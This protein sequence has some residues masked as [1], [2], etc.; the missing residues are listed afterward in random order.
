MARNYKAGILIT[1]DSKGA[2]KAIN[3]TAKEVEDL[4]KTT[5]KSQKHHKAYSKSIVGGFSDMAAKAA[6]WGAAAV[7][8]GAVA[9]AA[10]VKSGL[11][12]ADALAK[13]SDKLGVTTEALA[14]LRFAAEQTG[15]ETKT[16]DIALQRFT[17]RLADAAA[18][19]GPAVKA[20]DALGLSAKDLVELS[21]DKAFARVAEQMGNVDN[22]TSKVALAFKLFDSEGVALVNTLALGESGLAAMAEEADILGLS[23]SRIDAAK[24]EAANDAINKISKGFSGLSQHLAVKFAPILT[25]IADRMFGVA[26]EAGG[27][28]EVATGVFDYMVKAVG[29]VAN[30]IRGL[31]I[32]FKTIGLAVEVFAY[33]FIKSFDVILSG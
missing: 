10:M 4:G 28:G 6:K 1:G 13:T 14:R 22:Q 33:T 24:V 12:S 25:D 18:G 30:A 15:V 27:M 19:T 29:F 17:R 3:L 26:K 31:E 8:A 11:A 5:A 9:T 21:P 7:T 23:L 16:F 2:Q 20:F 32:I